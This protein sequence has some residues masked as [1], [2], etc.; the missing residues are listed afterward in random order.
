MPTTMSNIICY[1]LFF[2]CSRFR[3][4]NLF[5]VLFSFSPYFGLVNI[6]G[7]RLNND[8]KMQFAFLC[9]WAVLVPYK[10]T[11]DHSPGKSLEKSGNSR[12]VREKSG[13]CQRK[14]F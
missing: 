5:S 4:R 9:F 3:S 7:N 11:G 10:V 1:I 13:K 6:P 2:H 14:L 8:R 12:V